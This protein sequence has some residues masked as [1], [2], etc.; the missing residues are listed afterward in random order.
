MSRLRSSLRVL[1]RVLLWLVTIAEAG[2]MAIAGSAKFTGNGPEVWGEMFV[3]WGY[4]LWFAWVVGVVEIAFALLLLVPRLAAWA[5]S[6]LGIVMLGALATVVIHD[7]PL[8]VAGPIVNLVALA[9]VLGG[10][11]PVRWRPSSSVA[12]SDSGPQPHP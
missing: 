3:G 9:I 10:R 11:W 6:V 1:G 2:L 12:G 7:S 8:G 5:A 4:P